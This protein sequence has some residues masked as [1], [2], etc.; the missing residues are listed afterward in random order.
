MVVS[1]FMVNASLMLSF[2]LM[3]TRGDRLLARSTASLHCSS[4]D[5]L[6]HPP[7]PHLTLIVECLKGNFVV[8]FLFC[9]VNEYYHQRCK[10]YNYTSSNYTSAVQEQL[11]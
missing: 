10:K 2:Y 7:P 4:L 9:R 8:L 11:Q 5:P 1:F 6:H 3:Q